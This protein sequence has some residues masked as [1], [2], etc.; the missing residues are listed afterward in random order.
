MAH[1][2]SN[3][4]KVLWRHDKKG[5]RAK[6]RKL[7]TRDP[8]A[9]ATHLNGYAKD[10]QDYVNELLSRRSPADIRREIAKTKREERE[11]NAEVV[12]E[13]RERAAFE[14]AQFRFV[15]LLL[16]LKTKSLRPILRKL[17]RE[18]KRL[19]KLKHPTSQQKRRRTVVVKLIRGYDS[20]GRVIEKHADEIRPEVRFLE[21]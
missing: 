7:K 19:D 15:N 1:G 11:R 17:E 20:I 9:M 6:L 8:G 16:D 3:E 13:K 2:L 18:L 14:R 10:N 5:M 21:D 4:A 12:R